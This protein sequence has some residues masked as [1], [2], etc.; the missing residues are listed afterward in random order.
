MT[1]RTAYSS[2]ETV[3]TLFTAK[4]KA[5]AEKGVDQRV[6][7]FLK[8][9]TNDETPVPAVEIDEDTV[10][11]MWGVTG[12]RLRVQIGPDT[13]SLLIE[14]S[15]KEYSLEGNQTKM[16]KVTKKCLSDISGRL[17]ALSD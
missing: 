1:R 10:K 6:L 3:L 7:K 13:E 15:G 17:E 16:V 4:R 2:V 9:T 8:V 5:I 11:L 12:I 14:K